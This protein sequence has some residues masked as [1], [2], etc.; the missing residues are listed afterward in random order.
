MVLD[1]DVEAAVLRQALL[2]DV[3]A[4]HDLQAH[5]QRRGD[6]GFLDQLLVEHAVDALAQAQDLLVRLDVDVRGLHLHR[7][8]EQHLQQAHHR[9][10]AVV[11]AEAAEV[12]VAVFQALVKLA[13]QL[14]DLAGAPV[15]AVEVVEQLALAHHRRLERLAQQAAQL[16]EGVEIEWIAHADQQAVALLDQQDGAETPRQCLGQALDQRRVELELA[17]VDVGNIELARQRLEQFLLGHEAE[18]D[19]RAAELGAAALLLLQGQLQLALADQSGLDQQVAQAHLALTQIDA[20][21][22]DAPPRACARSRA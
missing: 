18:I 17:Q 10:V 8:L 4:G 3:Q 6:A 20:I 2:G 12:E 22:Q 15:E 5:D 11:Q 7:I 14:G 1:P 21:H 16:V 13:G 9:G 19:H